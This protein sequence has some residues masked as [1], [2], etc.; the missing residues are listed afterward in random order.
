MKTQNKILRQL[1]SKEKIIKKNTN[2]LN[3]KLFS[4]KEYL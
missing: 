2:F 1:Y 3:E 4:K